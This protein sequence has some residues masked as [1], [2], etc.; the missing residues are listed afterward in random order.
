MNRLK[1]TLV[2]AVCVSLASQ[3]HVE[4]FIE[5]FIITLSVIV[6]P[7]LFYSYSEL[8]PLVTAFVTGIASPLF[9]ALMEYFV[10][11]Y[12]S[13]TVILVW[14]D[15]MFYFS[16]GI[17]FYSLYYR[18]EKKDL[19]GFI[20]AVFGCDFLSNMV[21]MSVR[22][23]I[24]GM[25]S[26]IIKGLIIIAAVR[27]FIVLMIIVF[28]KYY[29]SLLVREEHE[30]Q[31][32]NLILLTSG[33]KSEIY[34]MNKN[35]NEIED[36]MKKSFKV[37]K[38]LDE[39]CSDGNIRELALDI[40]K[41]VHEIKKDYIRVIKGLEA[42]SKENTE[43]ISMSIDDIMDILE[44]DTLEFI[45]GSEFNID[46]KFKAEMHFIVKAHFYLTAILRNLI[47]NSIEA[48]GKSKRGLVKLLVHENNDSYV[49]E[50]S[51][52]GSGIKGSN[53]DFIFNP[54]FSTKF[55]K[56]TGEI[57][58]GIGLTLVR[59]LVHDKFG[60]QISVKSAENKGTTFIISIPKC[61]FGGE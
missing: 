3:F 36:V 41:D 17:F 57:E 32:R 58:R 13:E 31:Y 51:D 29:K 14:P 24:M 44:L 34:F 16:Y 46:I 35:I 19:T 7:V 2:V 6:F 37:Y 43:V 22:T 30:N 39:G 25:D 56:S 11:G 38:A 9:R 18:K 28:M 20:L 54:G 27:S 21:E 26:K 45:K 49:F 59:D 60:G 33:F 10:Y 40:A 12:S 23:R 61:V 15:V 53:M 55:D 47:N 48:I 1:H 52:N 4:F 42:I 8:N 5:G 50:V